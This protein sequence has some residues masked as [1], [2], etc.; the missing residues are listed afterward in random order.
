MNKRV[1]EFFSIKETEYKFEMYDLTSLITILNVAFVLMGF[2][3]APIL[4]LVNCGMCEVLNVINKQHINA[5]ITQV[6]LVVLNAYFFT[7]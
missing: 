3:W 6:A 2:W 4:G 7:L 1:K 5:H